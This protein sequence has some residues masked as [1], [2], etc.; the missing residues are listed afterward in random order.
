MTIRASNWTKPAHLLGALGL[1]LGLLANSGCIEDADCGIC[2]PDNLILESISGINYASRK[3]N[4]LSPT[5]EGAN[6]P[7]D[8]DSGTYFIEDIGPCEETEE[9]KDSSRGAAEFCKISPLVTAFGIEF[10][11]NNLLDPTS[12]ELVRK[13][14]DN[15]QLFEV[16]DWKDK[17]LEIQGPITR[18]NGDFLKGGTERPDQI[19]RLVNLSCIQNLREN[20]GADFDNTSYEDPENNPCNQLGPD[21]LP[22]KMQVDG[23]MKSYHGLTSPFSSSC[24]TPEDTA[25]TC[26]SRCD[27][28]LSTQVSKYGLTET[29]PDRFFSTRDDVLGLMRDPN[30]LAAAQAIDPAVTVD[31]IDAPENMAFTCDPV[32]GDKYIAC[33]DFIPWVN[34]SEE[35]ERYR[36]AFGGDPLDYPLPYYDQLRELHPDDRP[37][38]L[39]RETAQCTST[40]QCLDDELHDL[41]GTECVGTVEE[42]I[43][44]ED[45]NVL[46]AAGT[47]CSPDQT[48]GCTNGVCLAQWVVTCRAAADTTGDQGYCIDRRF[49]DRAAA[50][51]YQPGRGFRACTVT[52]SGEEVCGTLGANQRFAFCDSNKDGTVTA[53]ECCSEDL[54]R[55]DLT[56]DESLDPGAA[57]DPFTQ[58][59]V[60]RDVFDRDETLPEPT[61]DCI[62]PDSGDLGDYADD[63]K[64]ANVFAVGCFDDDGELRPERAGQ[65]AVKFI[66]RNGGVVYDPAIKGFEFRPA[67][68][69]SVP[70]ADIEACAEDRG[71]VARRNKEDGWRANDVFA[72]ENFEDFDRAFCS[73]QEYTVVF[74]EPGGDN[75]YVEDKVGNTLEGKSIYKFETPEFHIVPDSGF[76]TDNLRI[77]ACDDFSI[78]FS[79]KFDMSPENVRKIEIWRVAEAD[80]TAQENFLPPRDGCDL[81]PVA[82][83]LFCAPDAATL[84][85]DGNECLPPCLTVNIENQLIGE[86]VVQIDPAEFGPVLKTDSTYRMVVPGL[87]NYEEGAEVDAGTGR[88]RYESAF[89]DACG[90][91][92]I[93]GGAD[94]ADFLYDFTIDKPKCKEDEDQD[95]VQLSCDNAPDFFNPNQADIDGDGIG[96]VVDLCPTVAGAANNTA[97]SDKDGVGNECDSC[98]QT[99]KQ[100]NDED[101]NV[102]AYL[103]VRN[104]P[105]QLD[106]DQD[107]IGDVCDNCVV[108]ANCE[109]FGPDAPYVVGDPID[110]DNAN[111]CQTASDSSSMIGEAC[112]G[113]MAETAAGVIG[114]GPDDDFDQDGL[115]NIRDGCPRQPIPEQIACE[116]DDECPADWACEPMD[117]LCNH[118]DSDGDGVG[119]ICDTCAFVAN[120]MQA[121]DGQMQDDD[122]D[123]DFVGRLCETNSSC[124]NR[125]DA[126]PFAFWEVAANGNCCTTALTEDDEGNLVNSITGNPLLDPDGAPVRIECET[127]DVEAGICRKLPGQVAVTPGIV[128]VPPGCEEALEDA[129]GENNQLTDEDFNGDLAA[130]WDNICFLP[131]FDQDYDG[132]GDICDLCKFDFDPEN[133]PFIDANGKVW[134]RD[135]AFCNGEYSI[136]TKCDDDEPVPTGGVEPTGGAES[137]GMEETGTPPGTE[138]GG[139]GG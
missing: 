139:S 48:E 30:A 101:A 93:L 5:C 18:Y 1:S 49:S 94:T 65:Y 137:G 82:G 41:P 96:D 34:R 32:E 40:T 45:G 14:P 72:T 131:Q 54:A 4:I 2:D 126:R 53:E 31:D 111:L 103:Q 102:P 106:T 62:C 89:W 121:M 98:R 129:G 47:T 86:V 60:A 39:E 117:G 6:C 8:F 135:G 59:V 132:Y 17:I 84:E 80:S 21:G 66:S 25:D 50:A 55:D 51:C 138:G 56:G 27:F 22:R 64:C 77:G 97:D 134:P 68:T 24:S 119:N 58:F 15:P 127:T 100:Y 23:V 11:F 113:D 105:F 61:R 10:V 78:R 124:A 116:S 26:C 123:G 46:V 20:E 3:V 118:L 109:D 70:R 69:G 90:M 63:A 29:P 110:Y 128:T 13:R 37:G 7:D 120:P 83:G 75:Q 108:T 19:T 79:N 112:E 12:V 44:D 88:T 36:Y 42:D 73:G 16:Y 52:E 122:E 85:I 35:R 92:L 104:I 57:C 71:L 91:P 87:T 9:A 74:Q 67:D 130:L 115:A 114:F 38:G 28:L 99:T 125:G 81:G 33:R 76:P 133:R 136:D 107:G 95:D 43:E